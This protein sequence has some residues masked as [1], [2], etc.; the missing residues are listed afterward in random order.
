MASEVDFAENDQRMFV[1]MPSTPAFYCVG[2]PKDRIRRL[3]EC[4]DGGAGDGLGSRRAN[5]KF[6]M[7]VQL[8]LETGVSSLDW[9]DKMNRLVPWVLLIL[10]ALCF[11]STCAGFQHTRIGYLDGRGAMK[12]VLPDSS[13]VCPNRIEIPLCFNEG[14]AWG[15]ASNGKYRIISHSGILT[16]Q[17]QQDIVFADRFSEGKSVI[18]VKIPNKKESSERSYGFIDS[19]AALVIDPQYEDCKAYSEGLAA[20]KRNNCWGFIDSN[21][22]LA[23][24]F[25]FANIGSFSEGLCEAVQTTSSGPKSGFIDHTGKFVLAPIY[26]PIYQGLQLKAGDTSSDL[27]FHDGSLRLNGRPSIEALCGSSEFR[28]GLA[29]VSLNQKI[30]FI[31]H[32]GNLVISP[33]F[34]YAGNFSEGLALFFDDRQ[35]CF[36]FVNRSGQIEISPR[37][38]F[39]LGFA[40]GVFCGWERGPTSKAAF[41]NHQGKKVFDTQSEF[42]GSFSEGLAPSGLGTVNPPNWN[43]RKPRS[44]TL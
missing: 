21:G 39:A 14:L 8:A 25:Q 12:I 32:K 17:P 16:K 23:I 2:F 18:A 20:V 40:N 44:S 43:G 35:H 7:D 38:V 5:T 31:D 34:R 27:V 41:F 22:A 26:E 36:G 28:S 6:C 10:A 11:L 24:P 33:R 29:P 19:N 30:G 1:I 9:L 4:D 37:F 42:A 3:C 13:D 15:V